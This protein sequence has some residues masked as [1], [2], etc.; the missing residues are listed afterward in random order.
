MTERMTNRARVTIAPA[1]HS[2][3]Q[4][5]E[6][7][8]FTNHA[9]AIGI[10]RRR[11][12]ARIVQE[13][14]D[15]VMDLSLQCKQAHWDLRGRMLRDVHLLLD[16]LAEE[17]GDGADRLAKRC[18]ALGVPADGRV[19]TLARG[20]HLESFAEGRIEDNHVVGLMVARLQVIA[21]VGRGR[22]TLLGELDPVSQNLVIEVLDG[23]EK[24]LGM[25][26]AY[27]PIDTR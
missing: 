16:E 6:R 14:L 7:A 1:V 11:G 22:L 27:R 12:A 9:V 25:F 5:E 3:D 21:E 10:D 17:A 18:L 20:T 4:R 13:L 15:D 19:A 26:E 2:I 23:I 24:T 8:A